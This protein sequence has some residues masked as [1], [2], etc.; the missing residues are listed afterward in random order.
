MT[1]R[2]R[3]IAPGVTMNCDDELPRNMSRLV[4]IDDLAGRGGLIVHLPI[5]S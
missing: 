3:T 2:S 1:C 4:G 5:W